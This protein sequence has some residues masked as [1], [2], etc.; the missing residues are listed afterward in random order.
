MSRRKRRGRAVD[1]ILL[2]DKP[3]GLSSNQALQQVKRLYQ[4]A[5]AGHTGS[6]DPLATGVLPICFGEATKFS[7]YLLDADKAYRA[8]CRLGMRTTTGDAEGE[9][10]EE[11]SIAALTQDRLDAALSQFRGA[12]EQIPPM[13]SAL[14]KDGQPLYKLARKGVEVERAARAVTIYALDQVSWRGDEWVLDVRCSKGTYI[15]TLV[16]DIGA[17]LGVGAYLTALRRTQVSGLEGEPTTLEQLEAWMAARAFAEMD[18]QLLPVDQALG[19]FPAL[20]L[21][22]DGSFYLQQGQSL[23]I[24]GAPNQGSLR[25]YDQDGGFLGLGQIDREGRVAPQR[26]RANEAITAAATVVPVEGDR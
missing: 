25:L 12:I 6:L 16:E 2:L 20:T 7:S 4:A 9:V 22:A 11:R 24:A 8:T 1:G 21:D 5:K 17:L 14:K 13:H 3:L 19:H 10:V 23:R 15:R 18:A 26:L